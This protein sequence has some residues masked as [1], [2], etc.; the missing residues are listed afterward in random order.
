MKAA[1]FRP[2][3][4]ILAAGLLPA[5]RAQQSPKQSAQVTLGLHAS[6]TAGASFTLHVQSEGETSPADVTGSGGGLTTAVQSAP[7]VFKVSPGKLYTLSI[8]S[9]AWHTA[10]VQFNLPPGYAVYQGPHGSPM[11][12]RTTFP[13]PDQGGG[14]ATY[15]ID[16]YLQPNDGASRLAPGYARAPHV[17]DV[18]WA[19]SAGVL[20]NGTSAG[21]LRWNAGS[22]V[23]GLLDAT[24]LNYVKPVDDE[25]GLVTYPDGAV[26][27]ITTLQT[28]IYVHRNSGSNSGY[29]IQVYPAGTAY[30]D[31]G[32]DGTQDFT[33]FSHADLI[34]YQ[35]SDPDTTFS[36]RVQ[37]KKTDQASGLVETWVLAQ[38]GTAP[39][40]TTTVTQTSSLRVITEVSVSGPGSG[41]RTETVTVAD[42]GGTVATKKS[43]IYQ[44]YPWGEELL[45]ETA[46]PDGLALTTTYDYYGT[47]AGDGH[48]SKLKSVKRADG[49]WVLYDYYDD[50]ARW[51]ELAGVY[52][53][54]QDG[55]ADPTT[56]TASNCRYTSY[57]YAGERSV[58]QELPAGSQTSI[59]GTTTARTAISS[60][61]ATSSDYNEPLRTDSIQAF[62]S[63][64]SSQTTTSVVFHSAADLTYNGRLYSVVNPDGTKTSASYQIVS[65]PSS[66]IASTH[67]GS[68]ASFSLTPNASA[69]PGF[70][71]ETYL[72]GTA[73]QGDSAAV[74]ATTDGMSGGKNL[75]PIWMT[76]YRSY[77]RQ[78]VHDP[79][80]NPIFDITQVWT[81][82]AY[83]PISWQECT[84]TDDNLVASCQKSDGELTT[85]TYQAGRILTQTNP[86]GTK[87]TNTYDGLLRVTKAAKAAAP[88]FSGYASQPEIDATY[89]YDA[90]GHVLSTATA[91]AGGPS[92]SATAVYN[93]AGLPTSQTDTTGL[94][95]T[96]AYANG[97]RT[98]TSTLANGGTQVADH[99]IDGTAKSVTGTGVVAQ[100]YGC[101]VNSD[102]TI[103]CQS[104][105]GTATSSRVSTTTSDWLGRTLSQTSPAFGGGT[106][107]AQAFYNSSG[108]LTKTTRTGVAATLY[109][110]DGLGD[111]QYSGLDV[112]GNGTL[113][114]GGTDRIAESRTQVYT[115]GTSWW[116]QNLSYVFNQPGSSAPLLQSESRQKLVP[117]DY[118]GGNYGAGVVLNEADT[119]D[120]FR[121]LTVQKAVTNPANLLLTQT[122]TLPDST[123][124]QV[125]V[126]YNGLLVSQTSAQN[127]T[128]TFTYDGLGR[129]VGAH[130]PRKGNSTLAYFTSGSGAT[131][132]LSS[133]TDEAGNTTSFGYDPATGLLASQTDALGGTVYHGYD[134]LGREIKTWG[135]ATYPVA[136]AY[137]S[138]GQKVAQ[139]TFRSTGTNFGASSWP[140]SDDGGDPLAPNPSSWTS[141]DVTTWAYDAATGLLTTKTDPLLHAVGYSYN[142]NN[143]LATRTWSRGTTTT[144]S[145]DPATGEETGVSYSDGTPALTYTYNRLGQSATVADAAGTRTFAYSAA[146]TQLQSESLP[147]YLG[148]RI[149]T[150][151]YDTTTSGALGRASGFS[152]GTSGSPASDEDISYGYDSL[153]RLNGVSAGGGPALTY[154]FVANS[155]LIS[156]ISDAGSNWV[157]SR[158]WLGNR[159]LLDTLETKTGAASIAKFQYLSD[160]L[161][162]RTSKVS[163]GSLFSRYENGGLTEHFSYDARSELTDDEAYQTTSTSDTTTPVLGR[164]FAYTFDQIGNRLTSSVDGAT[165]NYTANAANEYTQR[166]VPGTYALSGFAPNSATLTVNSAT[167]ASAEKQGDYYEHNVAASNAAG[168]L[169]TEFTVGSSATISGTITRGSFLA[170][171][172]ELYLYDADGNLLKDGRWHYD[173]DGEN[174]LIAMETIGNRSGDSTAVWTSGLSQTKITF[175]YDYLGRRIDKKLFSWSGSA[176][177]PLAS[178]GETRFLYD[179]WNLA[180][181]YDATGGSFG[182]R[183]R[184]YVWGLD[185]SWTLQGGGGVGGLL[186]TISASGVVNM[187]AYDGNGNVMGLTDRSTGAVNA[188]YEY[189]PWGEALRATGLYAQ[190]NP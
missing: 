64:S 61:I 42:A 46:D 175:A 10:D 85:Y 187:V 6:I 164:H 188:A 132:Q 91:A 183:L 76:P 22:V 158:T 142:A 119:Y 19:V 50:F 67:S 66:A 93:Q 125:S 171:S 177:T 186:A 8:T 109:Q 136:I 157:Q 112:N 117:Y 126:S 173:W 180:G 30:T 140:L 33:G 35:I 135:S 4:W 31:P 68:Y 90:A 154:G 17:G 34:E 181:D 153:G 41:Q 26:K 12:P 16:F 103:T 172:P 32:G 65:D 156:G 92:L 122:T 190:Q 86:D 139:R 23:E 141:G 144:Y 14:S 105:I 13:T 72:F 113:D 128:T 106:L 127:L 29:T 178:S 58:Y 121:N 149:L 130:D 82:S 170:Q 101:S 160:A 184:S 37:I 143:Q 73:S 47:S 49:S 78:I 148:S 145:Y 39:N 3:S 116:V 134:R 84:Y 20:S 1:R 176:W 162:R 161:G 81:G 115:D 88:G 79:A 179:G 52:Q 53:P 129:Q 166:T 36:G 104:N 110:Y 108:Q 28:E 15:A 111:L 45:S 159:D 77:R 102:G 69:S 155:N 56:A 123:A 63:A 5:A 185:L 107:S 95:S 87:V 75:S 169:W 18:S 59:N 168:P 60:S 74:Q 25:A 189:S 98:V 96:L 151:K 167:V 147:S 27:L 133:A 163:S 54:W 43:R 70:F 131:G 7:E 38:S 174:R 100:Y 118:A 152:L 138:L 89:T 40:M 99:R 9:S 21:T 114:L 62:S 97:A 137:D 124:P 83:Q 55:P 182:T 94:T 11:L 48:Y 24:A 2:L 165:V 80:G 57:S 120:L 150:R 44:S 146:T 51:G 71:C